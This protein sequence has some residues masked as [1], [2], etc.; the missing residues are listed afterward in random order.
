MH[1]DLFTHNAVTNTLHAVSSQPPS[2][3]VIRR[4]RATFMPASGKERVFYGRALDPQRE[5]AKLMR[6]GL[7]SHEGA[8]AAEVLNPKP[9]TNFQQRHLNHKESSYLSHQNAPLGQQSLNGPQ[10]PANIDVKE[11]RFGVVTVRGESPHHS[12]LSFR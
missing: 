3:D 10:L 11:H 9:I 7:T 12:F 8:R 1:A 2:P 5:W 4:F 6:H